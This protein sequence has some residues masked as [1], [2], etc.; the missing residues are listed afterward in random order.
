MKRRR[1]NSCGVDETSS[2]VDKEAGEG[3]PVDS[4]GWAL[5]EGPG[6]ELSWV[7]EDEG[8]RNVLTNRR[9]VR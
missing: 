4:C 5:V 6:E 7:V 8:V 2:A 9:T 3:A 1:G